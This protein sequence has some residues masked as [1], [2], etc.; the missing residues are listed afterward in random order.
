[1]ADRAAFRRRG[2]SRHLRELQRAGI[3]D[4]HVTIEPHEK[5]G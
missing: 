1:M 5:R 3:R 4:R 2:R